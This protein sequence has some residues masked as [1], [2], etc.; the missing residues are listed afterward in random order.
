MC[1]NSV[2]SMPYYAN[3][4]LVTGHIGYVEKQGFI[5]Q[6]VILLLVLL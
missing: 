1:E 2:F 3:K 6:C 4:V 5:K